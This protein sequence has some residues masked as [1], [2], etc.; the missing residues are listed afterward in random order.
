MYPHLEFTAPPPVDVAERNTFQTA[1]YAAN[2][3]EAGHAAEEA[4]VAAHAT[5]WYQL[6]A[7]RRAVH[8]MLT[9]HS[10][11]VYSGV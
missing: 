3:V 1:G 9:I 2:A 11:S 6:A 10:L 8:T 7:S 5:T 4:K